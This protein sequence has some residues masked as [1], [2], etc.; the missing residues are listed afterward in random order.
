MYLE[1]RKNVNGGNVPIYK[2]TNRTG[3][4]ALFLYPGDI[5][6]IEMTGS[7]LERNEQLEKE[8]KGT[9]QKILAITPE[10]KFRNYYFYFHWRN[11]LQLISNSR[12]ISAQ[13]SD[14]I[15]K[16]Q[17]YSDVSKLNSNDCDNKKIFCFQWTDKLGF[18]YIT[19]NLIVETYNAN[20]SV[21][22]NL[23]Y[24]TRYV[25]KEDGELR[26]AQ[27]WM[28]QGSLKRRIDLESCVREKCITPGILET[29]PEDVRSFFVELGLIKRPKIIKG[30][31]NESSSVS[32]KFVAK[33][34]HTPFNRWLNIMKITEEEGHIEGST[35]EDYHLDKVKDDVEYSYKI[36]PVFELGLGLNY[37]NLNQEGDLGTYKVNEYGVSINGGIVFPIFLDFEL[38]IRADAS[39][40]L[41][42]QNKN[43]DFTVPLNI[44]NDLMLAI[45]ILDGRSILYFGPGVNF[46][47]LFTTD[48]II[49]YRSLF[50]GH[51]SVGYFSP[52]FF[53]NIHYGLTGRDFNTSSTDS[54]W[55][56]TLGMNKVSSRNKQKLNSIALK[57]MGYT[58]HDEQVDLLSDAIQNNS[59]HV[60][61]GSVIYSWEL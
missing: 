40:P 25:D 30:T 2:Q 16:V 6:I 58:Y 7:E 11:F 26:W 53:G 60:M 32:K 15:N 38:Q 43:V 12:G 21:K 19:E 10:G 47:S 57:F 13:P 37:Y 50:G 14:E 36:H 45:P 9:W 42:K 1:V 5:V 23:V 31:E 44:L 4:P 33:E 51:I 54:E 3:R 49:G 48:T 28:K 61:Q 17:V 29:H 24:F 20:K 46:R 18:I 52:N 27:G 59:Y 41:L 8:D 55:S 34:G 22:G 35:Q 39:V 56:V